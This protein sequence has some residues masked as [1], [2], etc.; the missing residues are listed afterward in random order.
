MDSPA[1]QGCRELQGKVAELEAKLQAAMEL[2]AELM[3]KL[4]DK[5]LPKSGTPSQEPK[6]GKAPVKKATGKKPGAQPGHSPH[7]KQMLP[8]E[9]VTKTVPLVPDQCEHCQRALPAKAGPFDPVPTRFQIADL[10][11]LKATIIEYQGHARTCRC[12]GKITQAKIPA[13][14]RAHSIGPGL[15]AFMSYLV[16]VCG[17]SK[18]KVE[19]LIESVFEVP[20]SLG[21]ISN[22]EQEVSVALAPAHREALESVREA[23]IKHADE[24]GWKKAGHKRWLWVVATNTVVVFV[25]HR[26]RNAAVVMWLL[27]VKMRGVL[28]SDRWRAYDHVPIGQRQICWAHLKRNFEKWLDEKGKAKEIGEACLTL[29]DR[30]FEVWHLYRGGALSW[31]D[32]DERMATLMTELLAV[33]EKGTRSRHR[34]L[35]RFCG[36]VIEVYPAL[37]TFVVTPGV[38]PTNNHAERVQR[39]AVL[40]RKNCFGCHSDAGCRFAERLLTAVQSLRSQGRSVLEYLK[41]TI[42]AHR[43]GI[44]GPSLLPIW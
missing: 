14:I 10:P 35:A 41:A 18:R 22:L 31:A 36:R 3:R 8:P 38:E 6:F 4:Q 9:R 19:E 32:M 30:I 27:G 34:K 33:L 43:N 39:L 2:I 23:P 11:E 13:D 28:C 20:V 17:L 42:D 16:G 7:V 21:T 26:L 24:T 29:K 40:W 44:H 37:W 15:T 25:I 1:C 5:D 12:C